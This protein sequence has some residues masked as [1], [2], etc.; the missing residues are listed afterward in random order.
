MLLYA[1]TNTATCTRHTTT[2]HQIHL[3]HAYNIHTTT[4]QHPYNTHTTSTQHPYNSHTT[5][6]HSHPPTNTP[7]PILALPTPPVQPS[8][9]LTPTPLPPPSSSPS[10]RPPPPPLLRHTAPIHPYSLHASR[11]TGI[12]GIQTDT[13][14]H[15]HRHT[16]RHSLFLHEPRPRLKI[17]LS[18]SPPSSGTPASASPP[19]PVPLPVSACC[20]PSSQ[21]PHRASDLPLEMGAPVKLFP[22][23]RVCIIL[24]YSTYLAGPLPGT[25]AMQ[26]LCYHLSSKLSCPS[27]PIT[28]PGRYKVKLTYLGNYLSALPSPPPP[29]FPY[30]YYHVLDVSPLH[31]LPVIPTPM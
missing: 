21:L 10:L 8:G 15:I 26:E 7:T 1:I 30:P 2:S 17:G 19:L 5:H 12:K 14:R 20:R 22:V 23:L 18:T 31:P 9:L 13:H 11:G 29:A 28:I 24:P 27:Y 4:I 6:I 3:Q 16:L 25:D